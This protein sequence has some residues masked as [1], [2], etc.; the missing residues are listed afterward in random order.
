[1]L[2]NDITIFHCDGEPRCINRRLQNTF[3]EEVAASWFT[4]TANSNP[5]GRQILAKPLW[6]NK[7]I[8]VNIPLNKNRMIAKGVIRIKNIYNV[9]EK[10]LMTA[11]EL[12]SCYN[13]SNFLV[14]NSILLAIPGHWK[15]ILGNEKPVNEETS[16]MFKEV[17]STMK[18][19]QWS[20]PKLLSSLPLTVPEKAI[21]KW[22]SELDLP[23]SAV[24]SDLF[25]KIYSYTA[26]FRLRW[27]QLRIM[28][29]IIPA[30]SRLNLYGILSSG[31]C[32]RC[33]G[34]RESLLHL[35]WL[36]PAVLGFWAQLRRIF[37]LRA[38]LSAPSVLLGTD[39]GCSRI[40]EKQFYL[41]A[42]LGKWY[43]WRCRY[44][45]AKPNMQGFIKMCIEYI[46]VEKYAAVVKNAMPKFNR[47]WHQLNE[48]LKNSKHPP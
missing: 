21:R 2:G 8:N 11:S 37:G 41:C 23:S 1:M 38:S 42:L 40:S 15:R 9:V 26:D 28:H 25:K 20:Y 16:E 3:W 6:Y 4:L 7:H 19:A 10:R 43:I 18:C 24:W 29:R 5:S 44:N 31:N 17:M 46:R 48:M 45:G 39:V 14:W 22:Q 30:N 33:P 36:C 27:L 35:F 12:H 34:V 13:V 47:D 32:D